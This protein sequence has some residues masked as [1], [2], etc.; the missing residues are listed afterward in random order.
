MFPIC[1]SIF[2]DFKVVELR[3]KTTGSK[4]MPGSDISELRDPGQLIPLSLSFLIC[5]IE[6][7]I[8]SLLGYCQN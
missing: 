8:V 2:W 1:C 5:R 3:V 7:I 6:V 4:S